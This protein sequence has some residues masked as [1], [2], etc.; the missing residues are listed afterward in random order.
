MARRVREP[1]AP[2]EAAVYCV[3]AL[4]LLSSV[5][6][7]VAIWGPGTIGEVGGREV[8]VEAPLGVGFGYANGG[9]SEVVG[10]LDQPTVSSDPLVGEK[11]GVSGYPVTMKYCDSSP[12]VMAQVLE[13]VRGLFPFVAALGFF[14]AFRRVLRHARRAGVF[15]SSVSRGLSILGCYMIAWGLARRSPLGSWTPRC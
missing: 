13:G 10:D 12:A 3:W 1:L 15:S 6:I 11:P 5:F 2:V 9:H 4:L 8:C 14:E 7:P